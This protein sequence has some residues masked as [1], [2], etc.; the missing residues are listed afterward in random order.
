MCESEPLLCILLLSSGALLGASAA[1]SLG[2]VLLRRR[3]RLVLSG[4]LDER[5]GPP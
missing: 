4:K 2:G 3:I 1:V 5:K